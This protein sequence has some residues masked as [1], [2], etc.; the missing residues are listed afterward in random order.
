LTSAS[1]SR[2]EDFFCKTAM[3]RREDILRCIDVTI[4]DRS[5]YTAL[6]SSYSKTFPALRAGAVVTHAAGLGGKRFVDFLEP[7]ACVSAFIR[8]HGSERTP[9]RIE[10]RLGLSGLRQSGSVHVANEH[11]TVAVGQTGAQFVQEVFP[12]VGDFGVNPSGPRSVA[13]PLS[14]R[15]RG[16]EIA[17]ETLGIDRWQAPVTEAC[18]VRQTQIDAEARDGAIQDRWDGRFIFVTSGAGHTDIEIPASATILAEVTGPQLIFAQTKTVPQRQ[19]ASG[20]VDLAG[21]IPNRSHLEGYPAQGTSRTAAFAPGQANLSMLPAAP[22]IFFRDLLH[23]LDGQV[24]GA[25]A[26]G[27][28]FE[29]RPE[30]VSRQEAPL[31]IKHFPGQFVAV[32]ENGVDLA[33]PIRKPRRVLVPDPQAQ[34]ANS[35]RSGTGHTYSLANMDAQATRENAANVQKCAMRVLRASLSLSGLNAGVTCEVLS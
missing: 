14:A 26:A 18:K 23:G 17:V 7:H 21:A 15:E 28:P 3:S 16:F 27:G 2:D 34:N 4:M 29:K 5:A 30:I 22:R 20:E 31:A 25:L 1:P 32:I 11:S 24:Q 9:S 35:G 19:P 10:H 12:P 13:R 6:P 8:Q 33:G